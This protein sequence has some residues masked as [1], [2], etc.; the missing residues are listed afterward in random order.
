[1]LFYVQ[2]FDIRLINHNR[3]DVI[4]ILN[5]ILKLLFDVK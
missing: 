5:M 4:F 1:M 2:I 3:Q